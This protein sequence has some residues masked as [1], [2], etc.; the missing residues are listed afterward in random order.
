MLINAQHITYHTPIRGGLFND[1]RFS[2]QPGEKVA[3]TGANGTGK[4]TLL[5][6]I[7]GLEKNFGGQ[8]QVA[9]RQHYVP[10]HYGHFN[11]LTVGEALGIAPLLEALQA[12]EE[13]ATDPLYYDLLERDWDIVA[14]CAAAFAHWG[15]TGIDLQQP[16]EQLSG[17]M[18]TRLFLSGIDL[19]DPAIV[20]LD[21]PTNH[22][23][24]NAR[25]QLYD[26]LENTNATVL[27][28][29][30]DRQLLQLCSP[31]WELQA[32]GMRVYG[33]NYDFYAQQQQ[34]E[35]AAREQ[36]LTNQEKAFKEARAKQQQALE[37]KQ[38][39]DTQARKNS[40]KSN[41]PAGYINARKNSAEHSVG[42]LKQVHGTKIQELRT[43]VQEA[44]AMVNMQ[45]IMKGYFGAPAL[46]RGK[47]LIQ[48]TAI[49]HGW[50]EGKL[51]WPQGFNVTLRSGDRLAISGKNGSGK[52]TLL[53][54]LQGNLL[55]MHG[56]IQIVSCTSL[57]LDQDYS[58]IDRQKTVLEQAQAYNDT[59]LEPALVHTLLANFLFMPDSWNKPCSVLSGGEML[60]LSLACMVLQNK[61]PDIIFLDEP[62]NNL[63]LDNIQ[64]LEQ[65]F[66]S[67]AGTLVVISHDTHFLEQVGITDT[68]QLEA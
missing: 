35:R 48:A 44:L 59:H 9:G 7:A 66:A 25:R 22:L 52:S 67:Y 61:T 62:V 64:M 50:Q 33:G 39:A 5:R 21:E 11:Q 68:L 41:D 17:G 58:L 14:R 27:L 55:P 57:L 20:L 2:L 53:N 12:V 43:N 36:E 28:T 46:H 3:L 16:L 29:S 6:I 24:R 23:D 38:R 31:I 56:S 19:F 49:N 15:I 42:K 40:R 37:R 65:I 4:T 47:M 32:D 63:D 18:K 34:V 54:L 30:H 51:L 1:L 26:W 45:Q 8:L 60:R 13:G 10:Q